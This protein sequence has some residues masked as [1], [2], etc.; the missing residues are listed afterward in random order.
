MGFGFTPM[1]FEQG[2][3]DLGEASPST[4]VKITIAIKLKNLERLESLFWSVS[5]PTSHQRGHYVSLEDIWNLTAVPESSSAVLEWVNTNCGRAASED[6]RCRV[7]VS[8][9]VRGK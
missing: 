9:C 1:P 6:S 4:R 7:R 8:D 5:D 2:W 3:K